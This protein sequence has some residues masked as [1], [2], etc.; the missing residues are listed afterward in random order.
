MSPRQ[1]GV[2]LQYFHDSLLQGLVDAVDLQVDLPGALDE[3]NKGIHRAGRGRS[4]RLRC[5]AA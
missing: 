4:A 2:R 3:L 1:Y 5:Y